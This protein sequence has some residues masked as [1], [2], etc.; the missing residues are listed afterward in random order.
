ML[1]VYLYGSGEC[2]QFGK[3]DIITY[4]Y[5]IGPIEKFIS[6][7][8]RVVPGFNTL[9]TNKVYKICCGGQHTLVLTTLGEVFSWGSNDEKALG[10]EGSPTELQKIDTIK[11]PM[12]N[13]AAGDCHSVAYNTDLN[14]LYVWGSYRVMLS[15]L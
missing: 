9:P 7:I 14:A 15:L 11:Y 13:I 12:N 5:R 3:D 1:D 2:D 8:P 10:R 4:I 6:K